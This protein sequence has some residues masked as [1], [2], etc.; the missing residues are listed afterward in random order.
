VHI[1]RADKVLP[2]GNLEPVSAEYAAHGI[3]EGAFSAKM[4]Q[5]AVEFL[6]ADLGA[7]G[8]TVVPVAIAE[9][10]ERQRADGLNPSIE[11]REVGAGEAQFILSQIRTR[12]HSTKVFN[13]LFNPGL[14]PKEWRTRSYSKFDDLI[15]DLDL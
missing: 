8:D 15:D 9:E 7:K 6:I 10:A 2:V 11:P 14:P 3:A 4:L 13:S 1:E 12:Q 5:G